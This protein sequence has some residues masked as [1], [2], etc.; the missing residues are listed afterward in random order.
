MAWWALFS[1]LIMWCTT[2]ISQ[3]VFFDSFIFWLSLGA[4][5]SLGYPEKKRF[6]HAEELAKVN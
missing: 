5:L 1:L 4:G 2:E 6:A 3:K